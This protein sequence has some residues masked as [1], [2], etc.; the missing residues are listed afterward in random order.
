MNDHDDLEGSDMEQVIALLEKADISY[1]AVLGDVDTG[2]ENL[3]QTDDLIEFI[4]DDEQNLIA[5][6]PVTH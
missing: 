4:F 2:E 6:R 5:I 1:S 3:V